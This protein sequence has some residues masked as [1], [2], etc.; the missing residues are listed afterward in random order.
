VGSMLELAPLREGA[1]LFERL[2]DPAAGLTKV[3][4]QTS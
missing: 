4:L 1:A 2:M 3:L